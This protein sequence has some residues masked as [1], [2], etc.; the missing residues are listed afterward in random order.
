MK[1]PMKN[2]GIELALA[3]TKARLSDFDVALRKDQERRQAE[4]ISLKAQG[5]ASIGR[6]T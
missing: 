5:G 6:K 1:E 3:L 2:P 4:R